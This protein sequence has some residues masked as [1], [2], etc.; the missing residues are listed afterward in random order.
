MLKVA[1]REQKMGRTQVSEWFFK[2]KS[3]RTF[4]EDAKHTGHLS[5]KPEE[6]SD[7]VKVLFLENRSITNHKVANVWNLIWISL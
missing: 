4:A 5:R 3:G 6:S 2:S 7:R 1:F